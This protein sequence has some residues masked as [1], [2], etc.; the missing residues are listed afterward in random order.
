ML[1]LVVLIRPEA[2]EAVILYVP[3]PSICPTM[4]D[5][6][7]PPAKKQGPTSAV[8]AFS[9]PHK[10]RRRC[11][12]AI[13][14][15]VDQVP[16]APALFVRRRHGIGDRPLAFRMRTKASEDG[17]TTA[18]ITYLCKRISRVCVSGHQGSRQATRRQRHDRS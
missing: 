9:P 6:C 12:T 8:R 3:C 11:A 16:R 1:L 14:W 13:G 2:R 7:V 15:S 10:A 18:L 4:R 5:L 17:I